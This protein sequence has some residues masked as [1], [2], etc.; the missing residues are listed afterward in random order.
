VAARRAAAA[1]LV[2]RKVLQD[3]ER[4]WL[5]PAMKEI[6]AGPLQKD[7]SRRVGGR[8][9]AVVMPT[10]LVVSV[11]SVPLYYVSH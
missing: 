7:K 10:P 6:L 3:T 8:V 2:G 4:L 9:H 5:C 1:F 11:F